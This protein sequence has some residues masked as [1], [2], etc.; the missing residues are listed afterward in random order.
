MVVREEGDGGSR[1]RCHHLWQVWMTTSCFMC[2]CGE[3]FWK[4]YMCVVVC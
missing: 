4:W 3:Y 1:G 2:V